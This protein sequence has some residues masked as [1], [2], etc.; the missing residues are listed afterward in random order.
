M[1]GAGNTLHAME[2]RDRGQP[3]RLPKPRVSRTILTLQKSKAG[4]EALY[5]RVKVPFFVS[6]LSVFLPLLPLLALCVLAKVW[7]Y[8]EVLT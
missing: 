7:G 1:N 2:T 3:N 4:G 5:C 8:F 6:T